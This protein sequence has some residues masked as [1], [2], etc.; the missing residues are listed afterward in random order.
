MRLANPTEGYKTF[1]ILTVIISVIGLG[2]P[3]AL[4]GG[5][6]GFVYSRISRRV[7]RAA[8]PVESKQPSFWQ[9]GIVAVLALI[10]GSSIIGTLGKITNFLV[11]QPANLK[12]QLPTVTVGVR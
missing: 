2:L 9:I 10:L 7:I 12:S 3:I 6:M 4:D 5:S 11:I 1:P 8:E